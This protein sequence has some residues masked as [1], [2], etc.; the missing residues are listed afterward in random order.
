[1]ASFSAP[2]ASLHPGIPGS[3]QKELRRISEICERAE[4]GEDV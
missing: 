1:M 3:I 4:H 2:L